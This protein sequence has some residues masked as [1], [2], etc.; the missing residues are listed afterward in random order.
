[1][2]GI[3]TTIGRAVVPFQG[4][5]GPVGRFGDAGFP[6]GNQYATGP[7]VD[8]AHQALARYQN[9]AD[10]AQ[11]ACDDQ[12]GFFQTVFNWATGNTS[13]VSICSAA[14]QMRMNIDEYSR[15]VND[16]TTTDDQ[17]AEILNF[18]A[19]ETDISDLQALAASTGVWTVMGN[20]IVRAPGTIAN[21]GA[22]VAGGIAINIPWWVYALGGVY[23]AVKLGWID[24]KTFARRRT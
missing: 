15:R 7:M 9:A 24:S 1:M 8:I 3:A 14:A 19:Q 10:T 2:E 6:G 21:W 18:I 4:M 22:D 23:L 11:R 20:A 5:R 17:L 12:S 16:P 13:T